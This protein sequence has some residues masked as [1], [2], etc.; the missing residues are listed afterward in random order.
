MR[1]I[2]PPTPDLS[3]FPVERPVQFP[4]TPDNRYMCSLV[5]YP[6]NGVAA[7]HVPFRL[8]RALAGAPEAA[9]APLERMVYLRW[10]RGSRRKLLEIDCVVP[11]RADVR[12]ALQGGFE[13]AIEGIVNAN[14]G[15]S[16]FAFRSE[17][18][19]TPEAGF[20]SDW[21]I[22]WWY[23]SDD[24]LV[25]NGV[26]CVASS[27]ELRVGAVDEVA[28]GSFYECANGCGVAPHD[29]TFA[30]SGGGGGWVEEGDSPEEAGG[31]GGGGEQST[32][33]CPTSNPECLQP[34]RYQDGE[35]ITLGLQ[36]VDMTRPICAEARD[37]A[38]SMFRLGQI[39]RGNPDIP[40]DP[41]HPH[42]ASTRSALLSI[43]WIIHIDQDFLDVSSAGGVAGL[44][45]HEAWHVLGH[46]SHD[47]EQGPPYGIFP[48]SEQQSC[49][50]PG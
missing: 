8:D 11:A 31:G 39:Y 45:L 35:K 6:G 47:E 36:M 9:D 16:E 21:I 19:E 7:R 49:I 3:G 29:G 28:I 37:K 42:D 26:S 14:Q 12:V 2:R 46:P 43:D 20:S 24:S 33:Y 38:W 18:P 48:Y 40:D 32:E 17:R 25:C 22:C 41:A 44:L 50:L 15:S 30:C 23:S 4:A 1:D 34:L 13:A 27:A 10:D 5:I